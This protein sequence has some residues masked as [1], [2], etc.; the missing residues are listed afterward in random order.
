MADFMI[1]KWELTHYDGLQAPP[2]VHDRGDEAFCVLRGL[3]RVLVGDDWVELGPGDHITVPAGTTH[4]FATAGPG[5]ADVLA[6]MTPEI[7]DLV[8]ALHT[9][10]SDAERAAAWARH[11]ARPVEL[12]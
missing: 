5:G 2:H 8:T 1:R 4:T 7:D 3:L 11:H 10:T 6:V 12:D 9:A